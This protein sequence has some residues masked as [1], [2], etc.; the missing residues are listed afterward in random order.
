MDSVAIFC[1]YNVNASKRIGKK[2]IM[3]CGM[4]AKIIAYRGTND[5]DVQFADGT[6][7]KHK[8]Y[9]NFMEGIIA[10]INI[11]KNVLM[12]LHLNSLARNE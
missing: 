6:I 4:E 1:A 2:H 3:N 5:I 9:H 10:N 11:C 8:T 12:K 7:V